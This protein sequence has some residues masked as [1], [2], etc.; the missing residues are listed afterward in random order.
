MGRPASSASIPTDSS[1][2]ATLLILRKFMHLFQFS[3]ITI[4]LERDT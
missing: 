3:S 4:D 1:V 2:A